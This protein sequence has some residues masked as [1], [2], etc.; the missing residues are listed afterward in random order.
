MR[1]QILNQRTKCNKLARLEKKLAKLAVL[2]AKKQLLL[3]P[4]LA[5]VVVSN[6]MDFLSLNYTEVKG[7]ILEVCSYKQRQKIEPILESTYVI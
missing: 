4:H 7:K 6:L 5:P 2:K 1:T 3:R